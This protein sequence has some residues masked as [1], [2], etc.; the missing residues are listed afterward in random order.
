MVGITAINR[1]VMQAF[2]ST[3]DEIAGKADLTVAGTQLGFD[4]AMLETVKQTPGVA[5]AS[6]SLVETLAMAD[7]PDE[8]LMVMGIDLFDDGYFR[9]SYEGVDKDVGH[10]S[11][12][13]EFVNSTDR[14]LV[15]ERFAKRHHLKVGDSFQLL[16]STEEGKKTFY[17]HGLLRETGPIKAYGG[18]VAVMNIDS[19]QVAF[20]DK[21]KGNLVTSIDVAIKPGF[22]V[23]SVRAALKAAIGPQLDVDRPTRRGANVEKML[24]SFQMGLNLGSG[25][26]LLVGVFLVY[27]TIAIGVVQRRREIGTLRALGGS[28]FRIRLMFTLEALL[29]GALGSAAGLPFGV[30]VARAAIGWVSTT[31]GSIYV[32]V[33]ATDVQVGAREL[34][35]GI[36]L[37]IGGSVFAAL[38]PAVL[39]S[40]VQPVEALRRDI[41]AGAGAA[42]L[43]SWPTLLGVLLLLLI[44]PVTFIQPPVENFPIGGY[45]AIFFTVMGASLVSPIVLRWLQ[46]VFQKPGQWLLGIA[47]R[48][49]ADNFARA[50][51][52]TA[53]PVSALAIGV[54]MTI[55]IAGFVGSFQ[56]SSNE[57]IRQTVPADLF[58][59][60][61]AKLAGVH[62]TPMPTDFGDR[63]EHLHPAIEH[64]D[65]IRIFPHDVLD[66]RVYIVAVTPEIY[67]TRG[68]PTF[69]EGHPPDPAERKAGMV[70]I[71]ENLMRRRNLH[72]GATFPVNTPTG[73]RTY[74][75]GGV[76]IDYTSDQGVIFMDRRIFAEQFDDKLVDTFEIYL[77]DTSKLEEVRALITEKFARERNLFVLS[78][79]ELRQE[80]VNLVQGAFS[81]TY[82]MEAVAVI[83]AL[84]GVINTLLAA[85]LDRTRE[86]GLLRA[87]GADRSHVIKLFSGEAA[88]I[89]LSGGLIGV[90]SGTVMG[91]IV[92]HVVA[93]QAGGWSFPY[94]FPWQ[95]AV[96]MVTAATVC[97]VIAGLSPARRAAGLDVVEALAYE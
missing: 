65:R 60:S 81:V 78:N 63:L 20:L 22:T 70:I 13:L 92:T 11:D 40:R 73:V 33:N 79:Q 42:G 25:V 10:L 76:I 80:A 7:S 75:V 9:S 31:V 86:I 41:A 50:P 36:A 19:A 90:L 77:N 3:I 32:R 29:M 89:G 45:L 93:T 28:R 67:Y 6:K 62:N 2:R 84:L 66:L 21:D 87:V 5:H 55:C 14:M 24:L 18:S 12:D 52:R 34:A 44:W 54:A 59:T 57:W 26:A 61:N 16:T 83:L 47:G 74:R 49:A 48:L 27:N 96:Q 94:V 95:I 71:S 1:S 82:A 88:L 15:S 35:F 58:I 37:G 17:V 30:V 43:A 39:A 38:R 51:A 53:V 85:V 8:S 68:K 72:V 69:I 56:R 91:S 46:R 23:D 97:A 4:G 64:V